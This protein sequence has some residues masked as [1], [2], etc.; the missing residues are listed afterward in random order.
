MSGNRVRTGLLLAALATAAC[1]GGSSGGSPAASATPS[2]KAGV[3]LTFSGDLVGTM[4]TLGQPAS[5]PP[6]TVG[7]NAGFV[8][9]G[10][11]PTTAKTALSGR[12][13]ARF[14][15]LVG[16][17]AVAMVVVVGGKYTGAGDYPAG[18]TSRITPPG[19][20]TAYSGK[21]GTVHVNA[22]L[23]SATVD[24]DFQKGTATIH[25]RGSLRC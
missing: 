3:N 2:P 12:W 24:A 15:G 10:V 20:T 8:L 18:P 11:Q 25:V 17:R 23:V 1:G 13:A 19:S 9:C 16:D 4:T 14:N 7:S 21:T 22:D 5:P 6:G